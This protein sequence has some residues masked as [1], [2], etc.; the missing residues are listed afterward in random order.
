M[1]FY[2]LLIVLLLSCIFPLSVHAKENKGRDSLRHLLP[3]AS[4]LPGWKLDT[5]PET[6]AGIELYHLING[7]AEVYMQAGFKRAILASYS[8]GKGK[9]INLEIFEMASPQSALNIYK[10]KI[11]PKGK[12]VAVGVDAVLEDYYLNF[13]SGPFQVT[14]SGYDAERKTVQM[15]LDMARVVAQRIRSFYT[16]E[17]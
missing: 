12:K 11:G 2:H 4:L 9:M 6:A 13:H 17:K 5:T 3:A 16:E 15:L 14:L 10:K 7:G 1:H 8:D